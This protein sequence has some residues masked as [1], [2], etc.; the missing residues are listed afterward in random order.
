[1]DTIYLFETHGPGNS[2][3]W[4]RTFLDGEN[5]TLSNDVGDLQYKEIKF[6]HALNHH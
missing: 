1:M 6:G 2:G 3:S 5:V 4:C